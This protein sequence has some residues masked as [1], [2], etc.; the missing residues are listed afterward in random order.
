MTQTN[1][2]PAAIVCGGSTGLGTAIVA[3]LI[4]LGYGVTVLGRDIDRL[5]SL[6]DSMMDQGVDGSLIHVFAADATST[7]DLQSAVASHLQVHHRLNV[8]VNVVGRSDR[9]TIESL[10]AATVHDLIDA[11]VISTLNCSQACLPALKESRGVI[12]NIGTLAAHV[13]PRYLGGYAIAKHAL[14]ALTRQ[15]RLECEADGVHVGL[16]SPG[17]IRSESRP[18]GNRYDVDHQTGVPQTAAGPGGGAKVKLLEADDVANAVVRCITHRQIEIIL[19]S[20]TR[21]LMA[22]DAVSPKLADWILSRK[23]AK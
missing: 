3:R 7:S 9:G 4:Y 22:I 12:V 13:C 8:L 21:L 11:N 23:T 19:P 17:P 14:R 10:D 6:R 18:A 1:D 20:K 2:L 15:M 5:N 16:V